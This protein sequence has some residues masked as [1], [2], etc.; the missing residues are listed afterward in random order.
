M[1]CA[2]ARKGGRVSLRARR[3]ARAR[4]PTLAD[5]NLSP[6]IDMVFILLI[7]FVVTTV[8]VEETG[9]ELAKPAAASGEDL[10]AQSLFLALDAG[11]QVY[12]DRQPVSLAEAGLIVRRQVARAPRP[13]VIQADRRAS[14]DALVRLI[15]TV[16]LAGA[17][18]VSLATQPGEAAP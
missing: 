15:D 7:F 6:L 4:P 14:A 10:S 8:F 16:N 9:I 5:I 18:A 17:P 12:H 11:G 13:V 1:R 2:A 3:H